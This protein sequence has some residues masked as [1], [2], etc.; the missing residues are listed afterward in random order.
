MGT[1]NN[2]GQFDCHRNAEP[3]EPMFVLLGRDPRAADLVRAWARSRR[4]DIEAGLR[5]KEDG[6][7]VNEAF[8]CAADMARFSREV[9]QPR[10]RG[11]PT[12]DGTQARA[13]D[14]PE[15]KLVSEEGVRFARDLPL[16]CCPESRPELQ[17]GVT[18]GTVGCIF[19]VRCPNCDHRTE[20]WRTEGEAWADWWGR[21]RGT[22]GKGLRTK[23]G[24]QDRA[25]PRSLLDCSAEEAGAIITE[26]WSNTR[27]RGK[28]PVADQP[29]RRERLSRVCQ[30]L[31]DLHKPCFVEGRPN[32]S[33]ASHFVH[34]DD[35]LEAADAL[36]G[37]LKGIEESRSASP[38]EPGAAV[39]ERLLRVLRDM[40]TDHLLDPSVGRRSGRD[41]LALFR[42][43]ASIRELEELLGEAFDPLGGTDR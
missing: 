25:K 35:V 23:D 39:R 14:Q 26:A 19:F 27:P 42:G 24:A 4:S 43:K 40:W 31:L 17:R 10:R 41:T 13:A 20:G 2:P 11:T 12:P 30:W 6:E 15:V 5:P 32:L 36:R 29:V 34:P 16:S 7:M 8:S 21:W 22:A 1:K 28:D 18:L 9:W 37:V 33:P 3:D 38:G